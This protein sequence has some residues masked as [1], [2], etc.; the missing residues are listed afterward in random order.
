MLSA[1]RIRLAP[2]APAA[3]LLARPP[4]HAAASA[5]LTAAYITAA[6]VAVLASPT[7]LP[8]LVF[9]AGVLP[10]VWARVGGGVALTFGAYYAAVYAADAAAG[11]PR[12][13]PVAAAFYRATVWARAAL[14]VLLGATALAH[15]VPGVGLLAAANGVGAAAMAVALAKDGKGGGGVQ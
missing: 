12:S 3:S 8:R 13:A 2:H 11:G 15:G 14:A 6:G 5:R 9:G 7:R 1:S 10:A 4:S